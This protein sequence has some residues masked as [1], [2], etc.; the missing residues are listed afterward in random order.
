MATINSDAPLTSETPLPAFQKTIPTLH[1]LDHSQAQR[2]GWALEEVH[3]H[4]GLKYHA[5]NYPRK[6]PKNEDL[7]KISPMGKSPI[8]T[9]DDLEGKP[10]PGIQLVDG[11]LMETRLILEYINDN[12][13][14]RELWEP[15]TDAEKRRDIYFREFAC[16]SLLGR[17]DQALIVEII[18]SLL[19]FPLNKLLGL[20]FSPVV[21]ALRG[22]QIE[23]Y[24]HME[25]VLSDEQPYFS[26]GK[27]GIADFCIEFPIS[28]ALARGMC[29]A[30]KYPKIKAWH[31]MIT[32]RE[33]W[34]VAL[35]NG[36]GQKKYDLIYFGMKDTRYDKL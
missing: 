24:N 19:P 16:N 2:I 33:A 14:G 5:K 23:H 18:P 20:L 31:D 9:V 27:L 15:A 11:V 32:G 25:D 35:E 8:V 21:N 4:N 13:G 34:K 6:V 22:F 7:L 10:V 1:R 29:D 12:Y 36:G 30:T 17:V 26:G 3:A 28:I